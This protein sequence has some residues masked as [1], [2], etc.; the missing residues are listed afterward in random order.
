MAIYQVSKANYQ[1]RYANL[2]HDRLSAFLGGTAGDYQVES[3]GADFS[4]RVQADVN[5]ADLEVVLNDHGSLV[6]SA[7]KTQIV[8]DDIDSAE[9]ICAQPVM[10]GDAQLDYEIYLEGG[11][12]EFWGSIDVIDGQASLEFLTLIPGRYI[13]R[14][15]RQGAGRYADG[16]VEVEAI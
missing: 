2:L 6:L 4:V 11:G 3:M 16:F 12:R 5:Q 14:F 8:A 9:I 1:S 13:I 7:S 10:A 15:M